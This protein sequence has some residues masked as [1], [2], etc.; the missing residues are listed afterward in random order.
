VFQARSSPRRALS[1]VEV[2]VGVVVASVSL[3]PVVGYFSTLTMSGESEEAD[4]DAIS[5]ASNIMENLISP[6]LPFDKIDPAG[7]SSLTK[8]YGTISQA[9]FSDPKWER[10]VSEKTVGTERVRLSR[11][12]VEF[13]VYFFAGIYHDRP[14]VTGTSGTDYPAGTTPN[15][16]PTV[17]DVDRELTFSYIPGPYGE[18]SPSE[19]FRIDQTTADLVNNVKTLPG[20]PESLHPPVGGAQDM[21]LCPYRLLSYE[22]VSGKWVLKTTRETEKW[23]FNDQQNYFK[24]PGWVSPPSSMPEGFFVREGAKDY[25]PALRECLY[26]VTKRPP[27]SAPTWAYHPVITD[28]GMFLGTG[29]GALMKIVVGVKYPIYSFKVTP[30]GGPTEKE[31]WLVSL[32]AKLEES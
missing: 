28:Q 4:T 6:T 11:K 16:I 1:L 19:F 24:I 17:P 21:K 3:I 10:L 13:K 12:G 5:M 26:R 15:P 14:N 22:K 7:G 9:G 2:M 23:V 29:K 31:F 32:K 30:Q 27:V 18:R 25:R 20:S 8:A